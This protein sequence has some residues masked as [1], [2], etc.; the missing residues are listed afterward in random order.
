MNKQ[1]QGIYIRDVQPEDAEGVINVLHKTWLDTYPNEELGISR[2]DIE[3]SY[4]DSFTEEALG[5]QRKKF[6][7]IPKNEKRVVA[8]YGDMIVGVATMVRN[9]NNNEFRTIYVLP[10]YQ[11]RGVGKML[12]EEVKDFCDPSKDTIVDVADYTTKTIEFYKK[13][14]FVDTGKRFVDERFRLRDGKTFSE[15]ELVIKAKA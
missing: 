13:L 14:G 10:E 4:K 1:S 2:E 12:W 5:K 9:E 15:M 8:K 7:H 6:E 11:G 3:D